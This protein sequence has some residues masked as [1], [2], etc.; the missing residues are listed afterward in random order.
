MK[1]L[2]TVPVICWRSLWGWG[3]DARH[4]MSDKLVWHRLGLVFFSF[5]A[6]ERPS[7]I[8]FHW[9]ELQVLLEVLMVV[10]RD[11]QVECGMFFFF[12]ICNR[13]HSVLP[14]VDSPQCWGMVSCNWWCLSY[15]STLKQNHWKR[16]G[17]L[18]Y[19]NKSSLLLWSPLPVCIWSVYT[20]LYPP[21]CKHLLWPDEEFCSEPW[22][23]IV[24]G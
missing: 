11:V 17:S 10:W 14:I 6:S 12:F 7:T 1:G 8:H 22:F 24:V 16:I 20:I 19:R 9:S 3:Q 15:L 5:S 4:R 2:H 21:S 13:T 23:V 18:A